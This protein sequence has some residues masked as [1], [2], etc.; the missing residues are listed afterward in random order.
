MTT[1]KIATI[2]GVAAGV[3]L[4]MTCLVSA[5]GGG[6]GGAEMLAADAFASAGAEA[7]SSVGAAT[8]PAARPPEGGTGAV[9]APPTTPP[10]ATTPPVTPPVTPP[11][12]TPP[13]VAP[14]PAAPPPATPPPATPPA[15]TPPATTPP[16][17]TPPAMPPGLPPAAPATVTAWVRLAMENDSFVV[18]GSQSVRFGDGLNWV[19]K[20][21]TTTGTCSVGYFGSDPRAGKAKFCEVRVT[22]PAVAQTGKAPVVNTALIPKPSSAYATPRVRTLSA[23]ELA[24][25]VNQPSPSSIGSFREPCNFSHMAFDDPIVYPGQPGAGHLHTFLGNDQAN[26]SSTADSLMGSGNSTCTGGT[27]NRT[28]YWMPTLIDTR[29]GQPMVPT[30]SVFYYKLG[31]LGVKA[32]SVRSFPKGLRMIAGDPGNTS[33]IKSGNAGLE[34]VSGG[35]H[36]PAMPSCP[37]GDDLN[38]SVIFPQCWDGVNLDSPDHQSHMAYAT[39]K[40]C[41][42][43]HPVPLPEIALNVHYKISEPNS[44]AFLKLS[45]DNYSGPGGYSMHADWFNGWDSS[46]ND[47]FVKG[48]INGNMDCHAYLLGDGRILY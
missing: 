22:V 21:A 29:T 20:T 32:G 47:A 24:Y 3:S 1:K 44:G 41:P 19:A 15:A 10:P 4:L 31:Y 43:T 36:Q 27:L 9:T 2:P 33:P 26:A 8:V 30:E 12:A 34:C 23:A 28:S 37:V 13:P 11:A 14:P 18:A 5:C 17:A 25:P 40:G 45:S 7:A 39:G 16:P 48:C 38:L 46:T 6:T 42:S 35:G